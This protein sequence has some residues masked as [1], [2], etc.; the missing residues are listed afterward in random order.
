[1]RTQSF[2]FE[3]VALLVL[4][5]IPWPGPT[6][7][8]ISCPRD[9][10]RIVRKLIQKKWLP[11]LEKRS[12][13][14]GLECPFHPSRDIFGA[15]Q[16]AKQQHRPS[17]WACAFCGKSFYT[18]H[19]LD[20]HF[21][22]RHRDSI[23][24]AEDAVCLADYCDVM[25]CEVLAAREAQGPGLAGSGSGTDIEVWRSSQN[26]AH[27]TRTAL[28][29]SAPR[30]LAR[31]TAFPS[32]KAPQP[33]GQPQGQQQR[34]HKQQQQQTPRCPP[35]SQDGQQDREGDANATA[36]MC[37]RQG[38]GDADTLVDSSVPPAPPQ[39]QAQRLSEVQR[40][41][42]DCKPEEL[43]R[44]K[45]RC[46]ILVRDCIAGLLVNLSVQDFKEIEEELNRASCWYLTCDRYWEDSPVEVRASPWFLLALMGAMLAVGVVICYYIIWVLF[47]DPR[48]ESPSPSH[49][50]HPGAG[51]R[52][53][54]WAGYMAPVGDPLG[55]GHGLGYPAA[56]DLGQ[57]CYPGDLGE[58]D[59]QGDQYIYVT[60]PPDLK[61]RLLERS[62]CLVSSSSTI[63]V[64][65]TYPPHPL[66]AY[67]L[68]HLRPL[69][70]DTEPSM[71][72]APQPSTPSLSPSLHHH[73][74]HH[75]HHHHQQQQQHLQQ[76]HQ[77][78]QPM[79][80]PTPHLSH[81]HLHHQQHFPMHGSSSPS[82]HLSHLSQMSHL[83]HLA[84]MPR[85]S[86]LGGSTM[87][88]TP[89]PKQQEPN[90]YD[91]EWRI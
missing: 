82:P 30:D 21:D 85:G 18:E 2:S 70:N 62:L 67:P 81:H 11:V 15:Q 51:A 80:T 28:S 68:G 29:V 77:P 69:L 20:Q 50:G 12:V 88:S 54:P 43:S 36:D 57:A 61:R 25:R 64:G 16:A 46:E 55:L 24:M 33:Q 14:L 37:G 27:R 75:H 56:D 13:K 91:R 34:K 66:L 90:P 23:N 45:T 72:P 86:P 53:A 38:Q 76:H 59:A 89:G 39:Q 83:Q 87:A 4:I 79:A 9:S 47:D 31:V 6:V 52:V 58:L 63:S 5:L 48:C 74:A 32:L 3:I 73:H 10:A 65:S 7:F 42:A 40:F 19:H 71:R 26:M 41:K 17:Q 1:M 60:Y 44:L 8:K 78:S 35:M 84:Q 22:S 49:G